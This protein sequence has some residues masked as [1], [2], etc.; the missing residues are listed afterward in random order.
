MQCRDRAFDYFEGMGEFL[1]KPHYR[2][3]DLV[4]L[5][6][7]IVVLVLDVSVQCKAGRIEPHPVLVQPA[8]Q[9]AQKMHDYFVYIAQQ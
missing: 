7:L 5:K 1:E 3:P 2:W 9:A 6:R 4:L 8:F